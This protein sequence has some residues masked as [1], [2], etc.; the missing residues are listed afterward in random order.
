M[1]TRLFWVPD[2]V[3]ALFAGL[4][5]MEILATLLHQVTCAALQLALSETGFFET[6]EMHNRDIALLAHGISAIYRV[7]FQ[8]HSK[9]W[10]GGK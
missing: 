2:F 4:W 7:A 10:Q 9:K 3:H 8:K 5:S 1:T 6:L